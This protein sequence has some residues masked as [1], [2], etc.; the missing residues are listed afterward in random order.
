ML[1]AAREETIAAMSSDASEAIREKNI[2][3]AEDE[4]N[5]VFDSLNATV[6]FMVMAINR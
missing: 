6:Q 5:A 3:A 2:K 4:E 1:K